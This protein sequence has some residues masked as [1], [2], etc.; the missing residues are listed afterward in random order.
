M[1]KRRIDYRISCI[2]FFV[3]LCIPFFNAILSRIFAMFGLNE[4]LAMWPIFAVIYGGYFYLCIVR[5]RLLVPD[6]W[7][8]LLSVILFFAI[9]LIVHPEYEP[10]YARSDYGVLD[11]V[12]KPSAGIYIYLLIRLIDNPKQIKQ[13]IKI[14]AI[15]MYIYFGLFVIQ[16]L[17]RG[18]WIDISNKGYERHVSYNLSLGYNVLIFTLPFLYDFFEKKRPYDLAGA[19]IGMFI[20]L[21]AGSRGPFLDIAIFVLLY[22]MLKIWNAKT[23]IV[24]MFAIIAGAALLWFAYPYI[25]QGLAKL[26]DSLHVS[27]RFLTKLMAGT[28]TDDNHR[29]EIWAAAIR[30]IRTRP[31]GYGA[32]GSRHVLYKYIYVAHPHDFFLEVLIDFGVVVGTVIILWLLRWTVRLFKMKDMDEWKAV[33]LIFFARACQLLVSLTFWHSIGLWGVLAVGVCMNRASKGWRKV[34]QIAERSMS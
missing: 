29:A 18:Y 25:L 3:Y 13:T 31:L 9:T 30:M 23:R 10:W 7:V 4:D 14:S 21:V 15:P 22:V 20:M 32:M 6:F 24:V 17:R 19:A 26:M 33:F 5:R 2:L 16:A 28:I 11:Y 12:L 34:W 27:S 1:I 8:I